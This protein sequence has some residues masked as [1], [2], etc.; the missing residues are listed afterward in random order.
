LSCPLFSYALERVGEGRDCL[1]GF[2]SNN[3]VNNDDGLFVARAG[4]AAEGGRLLLLT[5][6]LIN[7]IVCSRCAER[8]MRDHACR[9]AVEPIVAKLAAA[10][11]GT[12]TTRWRLHRW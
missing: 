2:L 12:K 4:D 10:A 3:G 5:G 1:A 8:T 11:Q 6:W 9:Q 7:L